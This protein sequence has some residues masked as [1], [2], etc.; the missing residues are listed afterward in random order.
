MS[1]KQ[2]V[3]CAALHA[4]RVANVRKTMRDPVRRDKTMTFQ[5]RGATG[6]VRRDD[7]RWRDVHGELRRANARCVGAARV[8]HVTVLAMACVVR[9]LQK[10]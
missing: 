10:E 6:A 4:S 7:A 2:R 1:A 8:D 5:R 9:R 3:R